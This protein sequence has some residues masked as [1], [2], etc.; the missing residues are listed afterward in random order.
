MLPQYEGA[1][2]IDLDDDTGKTTVSC[3]MPGGSATLKANGLQDQKVTKLETCALGA[4]ST[5]CNTY[6][7]GSESMSEILNEAFPGAPPPTGDYGETLTVM[8]PYFDGACSID[9]DDNTGETK[10]ACSMP[11]FSATMLADG[12]MDQT[13]LQLKTCMLGSTGTS[14]QTYYYG[15]E[16]TSQIL[17][18]AFGKN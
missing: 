6:Y 9:L 1:C 11:G 7:P 8:I 13:P 10:V 2:G 12:T 4:G 16:S 5:S 18:E 15:T 14:C 3:S 17:A